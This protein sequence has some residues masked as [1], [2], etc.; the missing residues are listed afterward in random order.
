LITDDLQRRVFFLL[1]DF[2]TPQRLSNIKEVLITF[3]SKGGSC[4]IG[5][6]DTEQLNKPYTQDI[7][8]TIA[9]ACVTLVTVAVSDPRTAK[10][11][12]DKI[13][14]GE[15]FE[16]DEALS[17]VVSNYRDG[18]SMTERRKRQGRIIDS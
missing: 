15:I 5:I 16:T 7:A 14:A 13:G 12:I 1:D 17:M 3:R 10:Y 6:Q 18:V 2:G 11:L 9:N 8:D 4:W